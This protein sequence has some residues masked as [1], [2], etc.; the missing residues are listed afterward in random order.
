MFEQLDAII[1]TVRIALEQ[2]TPE[3]SADAVGKPLN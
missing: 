1:Q 3:L 2:T